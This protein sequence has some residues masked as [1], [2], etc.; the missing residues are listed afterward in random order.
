M[1]GALVGNRIPLP[2]VVKDNGN[3]HPF[4]PITPLWNPKAMTCAYTAA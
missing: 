4:H 2:D 1:N 3:V